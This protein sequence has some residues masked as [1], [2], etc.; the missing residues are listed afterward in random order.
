MK[1]IKKPQKYYKNENEN[2]G[3]ISKNINKNKKDKDTGL[4]TADKI[5]KRIGIEE[6]AIKAIMKPIKREGNKK[7]YSIKEVREELEQLKQWGKPY[8]WPD[9]I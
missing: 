7:Y 9:G 1:D 2:N 8:D 3:D 4:L 5:A 6:G